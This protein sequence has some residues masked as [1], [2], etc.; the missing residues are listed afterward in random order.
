MTSITA[1]FLSL[2]THLGYDGKPVLGSQVRQ[3]SLEW[4]NWCFLALSDDG[5]KLNGELVCD[6]QGFFHAIR[7]SLG[8]NGGYCGLF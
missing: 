4:S 1:W 5:Q 8:R 7:L 3:G 6:E 2:A